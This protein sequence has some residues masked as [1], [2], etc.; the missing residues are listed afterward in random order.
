M[1]L[2]EF[3]S[4][5]PCVC[6]ATGLSM[7][8]GFVSGAALLGSGRDT[9]VIAHLVCSHRKQLAGSVGECWGWVNMINVKILSVTIFTLA[10]NSN[11]LLQ[12][13]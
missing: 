7:S 8:Y 4:V 1:G 3:K 9:Q 11:L 12:I 13:R 2:E 10:D 5:S 6:S